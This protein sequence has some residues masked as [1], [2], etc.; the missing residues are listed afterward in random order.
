MLISFAHNTVLERTPKVLEDKSKN[1]NLEKWTGNM[2][3]NSF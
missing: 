3:C 2:G 1:K